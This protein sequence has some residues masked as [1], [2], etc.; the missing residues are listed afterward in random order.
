MCRE[1]LAKE[2][3]PY[4]GNAEALGFPALI[5]LSRAKEAIADLE[6][7]IGLP[8]FEIPGLPPSIPGLRLKTAFE[9]ELIKR[10]VLTLFQQKVL[11]TQWTRQ[12][13]F[14][15][16][17]GQKNRHITTVRARGAILKTGSI[18]IICK[19][20]IQKAMQLTRQD[21]KST[22]NS[23]HWTGPASRPLRHCLQQ[24][25]FLHIRIG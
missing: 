19:Y 10:N 16:N 6:K 11:E 25:P 8:V 22:K 18:G 15:F 5:G 3:L 21:W 13:G 12:N 24:A 9:Y 17:I 7:H 20:S 14:T 23:G 1:E 2:I 4:V